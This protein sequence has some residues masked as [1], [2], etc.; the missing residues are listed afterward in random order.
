[1]WWHLTTNYITSCRNVTKNS[2]TIF[3]NLFICVFIYISV[4]GWL[5]EFYWSQTGIYVVPSSP[6]LTLEGLSS[7]SLDWLDSDKSISAETPQTQLTGSQTR[8]SSP[9]SKVTHIVPSFIV[10][11]TL[12][13]VWILN[14]V[15]VVEKHGFHPQQQQHYLLSLLYPSRGICA[16][17]QDRLKSQAVNPWQ[18]NYRL[19]L[20]VQS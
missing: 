6:N 15:Y 13:P 4:A 1:M 17:Y 2:S 8:P 18:V 16:A 5:T 11:S 14:V 12:E 9:L 7:F 20:W 3:C 10:S 19:T